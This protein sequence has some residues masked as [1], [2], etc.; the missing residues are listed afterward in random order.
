VGDRPNLNPIIAPRRLLESIEMA[1]GSYSASSLVD[2]QHTLGSDSEM[3]ETDQV[4]V[5]MG[6][7]SGADYDPGLCSLGQLLWDVYQLSLTL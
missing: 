2:S 7:G 5:E 6:S 3:P 1:C 4:D